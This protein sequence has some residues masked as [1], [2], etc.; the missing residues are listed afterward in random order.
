MQIMIGGMIMNNEENQK[1]R[2]GDTKITSVSVSKKFQDLMEQYNM[3]PTECFRRGVAV[4][5]CDLGVGMYQ[6]E[7]NE[8]RLK[9]VTEF[10][11]KVDSDEEF[12]RA[13]REKKRFMEI[14]KN[15]SQIRKITND[16]ANAGY[17]K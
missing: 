9:F 7:K 14:W 12:E 13:W 8:T 15:L 10:L 6:S 3:S 11:L 1:S 16:V 17:E 4:T 2:A 5:L